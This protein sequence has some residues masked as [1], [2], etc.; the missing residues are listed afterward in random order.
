MTSRAE[1]LIGWKT[2]DKWNTPSLSLENWRYLEHSSCTK[3]F[4]RQ[5]V[6]FFSC[7]SSKPGFNC[8]FFCIWVQV[9]PLR[10]RFTWNALSASFATWIH[11][12]GLYR[13]LVRHIYMQW[14]TTYVSHPL[15]CS[16][17]YV[18]CSIVPPRLENLKCI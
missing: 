5:W 12:A 3:G 6:K 18:S 13:S 7:W 11:K 10:S 4:F 14:L 8:F 16:W 2:G 9:L 1:L 17:Q 15:Q